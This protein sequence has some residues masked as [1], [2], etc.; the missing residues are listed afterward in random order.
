MARRTLKEYNN[1]VDKDY[2]SEQEVYSWLEGK[3]VKHFL[4]TAKIP[5]QFF[6][7]KEFLTKL[8]EV[9]YP[10]FIKLIPKSLLLNES[11]LD[12]VKKLMNKKWSHQ[13]F[14]YLPAKLRGNKSFVMH[15]L[16]G[17]DT[18]SASYTANGTWIYKSC[19][20]R[21][22]N[23]REVV[24]EAIRC[25][26][27]PSKIAKKFKSDKSIL[28]S[29]AKNN[30]PVSD[31]EYLQFDKNKIT[32]NLA[33]TLMKLNPSYYEF[34]DSRS[35]RRKRFA[36]LY[37]KNNILGYEK[38]TKSLRLDNEI[39]E[40]AL[41]RDPHLIRFNDV[42]DII[43][44]DFSKFNFSNLVRTCLYE[45]CEKELSSQNADIFRIASAKKVIFKPS[46]KEGMKSL[47]NSWHFDK[48]KALK[49]MDRLHKE[50]ESIYRLWSKLD[51]IFSTKL[52]YD[53]KQD[54]D[55]HLKFIELGASGSRYGQYKKVND[56]ETS[57]YLE[58]LLFAKG[59]YLGLRLEGNKRIRE[60]MI[61]K[62]CLRANLVKGNFRFV[63]INIDNLDSQEQKDLVKDSF[64][65]LLLLPC[66]GLD[67][68]SLWKGLNIDETRKLLMHSNFKWYPNFLKKLDMKSF[69][70]DVEIAIKFFNGWPDKEGMK[71]FDLKYLLKNPTFKKYLD[72]VRQI[73]VHTSDMKTLPIY[74]KSNKKFVMKVLRF[75]IKNY[76]E[77][78]S[79]MKTH[80]EITDWIFT[81]A[82]RFSK[83][84]SPSDFKK[85]DTTN[86]HPVCRKI[87]HRQYLS[88]CDDSIFEKAL[89]KKKLL[90]IEDFKKAS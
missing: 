64:Y 38:L 67:K 14:Q 87:I 46:S 8:S 59:K 80:R 71:F 39:M 51:S 21:L 22:Q 86:L 5:Y 9:H 25:G 54:K 75:D 78:P 77:L 49:E 27:D 32:E 33:K 55:I 43:K 31:L 89:M 45:F 13:V 82:P 85:I 79:I 30:V 6:S 44:K 90:C 50:E 74:L 57:K 72:N 56:P 36:R 37:I 48:Q 16:E 10:D 11:N 19:H 52:S 26:L 29:F 18:S 73:T 68:I 58:K 42:E 24:L 76:K 65:N 53:L 17:Q 69:S 7:N 20:P 1:Y 62:M 84:L 2:L 63:N 83:Y 23:D 28:L 60:Y 12:F 88:K 61:R 70:R 41:S 66:F 3:D 47:C 15:L 35:R 34:L 40:Y 4:P 81:V